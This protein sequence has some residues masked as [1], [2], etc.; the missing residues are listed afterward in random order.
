[1]TEDRIRNDGATESTSV[2]ETR[3]QSEGTRES[4]SA[5]CPLPSDP[6][7]SHQSEHERLP[8][9]QKDL[10]DRGAEST[11]AFCPLPS[12]SPHRSGLLPFLRG[13]LVM[14]LLLLNLILWGR[15]Q[16]AEVD[17]APR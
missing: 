17:S 15:G 4:T 7:T 12:D 8:Q 14:T 10:L 11:S 6:D 2:T 16:K 3:V 5:F 1:M 13:V 9:H